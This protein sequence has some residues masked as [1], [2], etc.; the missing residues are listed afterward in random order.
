M[1]ELTYPQMAVLFRAV[2]AVTNKC[3]HVEGNIVFTKDSFNKEYSETERTYVTTSNNKAFQPNMSG[4]SIYGSSLDGS[5]PMVRLDGF[6]KAEKGGKDG[7]EIERCYMPDD[8]YAI[9]LEA[10]AKQR[11]NALKPEGANAKR[12]PR[13]GGNMDSHNAVSRYADIYICSDCGTEEALLDLAGKPL[14]ASKWWVFTQT[15]L[16]SEKTMEAD[17]GADV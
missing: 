14:R 9:A 12:C 11:L 7:W 1:K 16:L 13:C 2:E 15:G 8:D 6:M 10:Y 3:V 17:D 4:Y 5:D